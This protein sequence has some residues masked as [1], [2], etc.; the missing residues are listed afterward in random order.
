MAPDPAGQV[1]IALDRLAGDLPALGVALSGGGDSTALLHIAAEWAGERKLMVATVDHGLREGSAAE[2]RAA[3]DHARALGLSH[4]VLRWARDTE[5]GNLMAEARDARLR[6]LS[7]WA[8]RNDLPAVLLGHTRD[9]VAETLIMRLMRGAGVDGLAGMA[10]WRDAFGVRWLRP[11][12]DVERADL[13]DWLLRREIGWVDDPSNDNSDFDRVRIR[14]VIAEL[15]IDTPSLA[16]AAR[17]LNDARNA[18]ALYAAEIS[19][20][21]EARRGTLTLMRGALRNAPTEVQ[22]RII[23]AA[24]RWVTGADY[25]PRR[26]AVAHALAGLTAGSRVTLDGA[27]LESDGER[28][29]VLREPAAAV[30]ASAASGKPLIWDNRWRIDGVEDGQQIAAVGLEDLGRLPWRNAGMPRDEAASTPAVR[31]DGQLI[32]APMLQQGSGVTCIPLRDIDDFQSML[33]RH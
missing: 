22:R 28:L 31:K 12:L 25:P 26:A 27:M 11:M 7:G 16:M 1:R 21:A 24:S 5:V 4:V 10:E 2:A 14:K 6:L 3:G 13:R 29:R 19:R 30:R 9:D 15:G 33:K 23:V 8:Q 20:G 17:N 32:A 18:L